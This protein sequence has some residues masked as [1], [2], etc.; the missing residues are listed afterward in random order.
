MLKNRGGGAR[1]CG[2]TVGAHGGRRGEM[3]RIGGGVWEVV[4]AGGG[5]GDGVHESL[6]VAG[7]S[8]KI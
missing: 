2:P 1:F 3:K 6:G 8:R 4:A 7:R 5:I